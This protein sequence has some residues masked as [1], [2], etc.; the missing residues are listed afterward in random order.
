MQRIVAEDPPMRL[1]AEEAMYRV[2]KRQGR[3][4][5]LDALLEEHWANS[6]PR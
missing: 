1:W 5:P 6:D 3:G 2:R 4:S